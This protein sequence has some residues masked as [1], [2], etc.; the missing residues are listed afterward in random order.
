MAKNKITQQK[1]APLAGTPGNPAKQNNTGAASVNTSSRTH[2]FILLAIAATTWLCLGACLQNQLG[3][4]DDIPY[5]REDSLIKNFSLEGIC[6]LFTHP[7]MG[8]YHPVTMFSYAFEYHCVQLDPWLYHFDN[9]VLHVL[10]VMTIYWLTFL[11]SGKTT[12]AAL[13]ALLF[14][15]HPMHVESIAWAASRKDLL[16]GL[17]YFAACVAYTYYVPGNKKKLAYGATLL[18]FVLALLSKATAVTL[19]L[20]LL[21]IDYLQARRFDKTLV[22]E[23]IPLLA[24]SVVFGIIAIKV[25]H[26]AGAMEMT[27]VSFAPWERLALAAYALF[28]YLWKAVLPIH[29]H[30][31]YPYPFKQH[32]VLPPIYYCYIGII[33]LCFWVVWKFLRT[34]RPVVFGLV[35]FLINIFLLL[36]LLP[37]GDAIVAER[38]SYM[39]YLGLF[40]IAGHF[41]GNI[42]KP[43]LDNRAR[44]ALAAILLGYMGWIGFLSNERCRV[45]YDE[46]ALWRDETEKEP[47]TAVRA[48]NNLGVIYYTRWQSAGNETEKKLLYDSA[49]YF[50]NR[51]K[52]LEPGLVNP[53]L[54]LGELQ[55]SAH[56]FDEA[57]Q[58]YFE[59]LKTNPRDGN[60]FF[61]L[62]I[63]NYVTQDM[64]SAGYYFRKVLDV[65]P[66]AQAWGNYGNYLAYVGRNDSARAAYDHAI[67][68]TT[69][70]YVPYMNRGNLNRKENRWNEA[71]NDYANALKINPDVGELYYL[72]SYCDTQNKDNKQ[73]VSDIDKAISLGYNK[74]D[75]P[76]Y[77]SLKNK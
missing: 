44:Y 14:G 55:R 61:G 38:Y 9:L 5:I 50:M 65:A 11:L 16:S 66:S 42:Y 54:A 39:P 51:A 2:L 36:Q 56:R 63:V 47:K 41:G 8:N 28:T 17:F 24:L 64:D 33:S 3:V 4:W 70:D 13:T 22:I 43:E 71:R 67:E 26:T 46:M 68:M 29:L 69:D 15:L 74:V 59:G 62:A 25:Q 34:N 57:K 49:A 77:N 60:L 75:L 6:N 32:G 37:V 72:R 27:K 18:L 31:L 10:V 19:P 76:Y 21:L 53:Y 58:T 20:A 52:T 48:Y 1:N 12:V 73:A 7:Y 40:I 45:W 35:F 30:C 23:K